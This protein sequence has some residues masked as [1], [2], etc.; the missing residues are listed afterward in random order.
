M[1]LCDVYLA[2]SDWEKGEISWLKGEERERAEGYVMPL[3]NMREK[4]WHKERYVYCHV[5]AVHPDFQRRGVGELIFKFD[6]AIAQQAGL[7]MYIESSKEGT[8][9]YEKMGCKRLEEK[10]V[11]ENGQ[12]AP[13]FVWMPEGASLPKAVKL[14]EG[15]K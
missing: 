5:M 13:L 14:A 12:E 1:A 10:L 6:M 8:R 7:P 11:D 4:L 15:K 9:L 2:P 3:W